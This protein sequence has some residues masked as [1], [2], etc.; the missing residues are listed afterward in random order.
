M[1]GIGRH[2]DLNR[3]IVHEPLSPQLLGRCEF[4]QLCGEIGVDLYRGLP[5]ALKTCLISP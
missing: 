4:R 1:S 5:I 2:N 3:E